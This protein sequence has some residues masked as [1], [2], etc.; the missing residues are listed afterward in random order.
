M[1]FTSDMQ[2]FVKLAQNAGDDIVRGTTIELFNGVIRDT[3]VLDGR[4]RGDWQT[5]VEKPASG[6]NG[7]IDTTDMG[8]DGGPSQAEVIANTPKEAGG[9][10]YLT[11]SMP[12][13]YGIEF[14]GRSKDKAPEGMVRRNLA[15]VHRNLQKQIRDKKV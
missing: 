3:P 1:S 15:R 11:N 6:E 13:A 2:R 4:L 10:T 14:E 5:T 7:R 9:E 12:Y 8:R